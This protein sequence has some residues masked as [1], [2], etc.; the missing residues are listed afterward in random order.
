MFDKIIY[1]ALRHRL[2]VVCI[3]AFVCVYGMV[4]LRH[5]PVDVFP[6]LNRPTVTILTEMDG[7]APED[8]ETMISKPLET[9]I[10]GLPNLTRIFSSSVTGLS[11]VRAEF[12]W[13]TELPVARLAI[14]ERLQVAKSRLPKDVVPF[15]SPSSSIMAEIQMIGVT[16]KDG[17]VSPAQL[18]TVADWQVRPK[19]LAIAGVSQ[20]SVLGGQAQEIEI[21]LDPDK[22]ARKQISLTDLAEKLQKLSL[23]S[24]GGFLQA[25]GREWLIRNYGRIRNLEDIGMTA[26]G[27]HFGKPVLLSDV[28]TI[29]YAGAPRR[30]D[31]SVNGNVG[32]V[33]MIQKQTGVDTVLLT[34]KI[35]EALNELNPLLPA[36]VQVEKDL[37]KQSS[38]IEASIGNV[39]EALRDGSIMVAIV[40]TLFL[41]NFRATT[42]TLT[43]LP[44]SLLIS[45]IVF[46]W[47][48]L[49]VNTMTLGGLAIAIGELV[50]DAIVD[51]E[52]VLRRLRENALRATPRPMLRVIFEAS[53]EIRNSIVIATLIVVL[54][55]FP[56]FFLPGLEGR[57][58]VPIGI[59]YV[60]SLVASLFVSVTVTPVMCSYLFKKVG[61]HG[62]KEAWLA[63]ILKAADRSILERILD[64][65]KVV[66]SAALVMLVGALAII[67]LLGRDFLP[68]FNEGSAMAEI[69]LPTGVSLD[70]SAEVA[71]KAEQALREV[72][73]VVS[74]ATRTGRSDDDE[75]A[76]GVNRSEMEIALRPSARTRAEVFDDIRDKVQSVLPEDGYVGITQPI[77][78][79]IDHI[80]S[81][82]KSQVAIKLFGADQRVLRQQGAEIR[83]AIQDVPGIVDLRVEGQAHFPQY[84]IYAER[85]NLAK[86]GMM[87]GEFVGSLEAMLQ[88]VHL[89]PILEKDRTV[90]VVLRLDLKH[91]DTLDKIKNLPVYA[92]P[93][94]T[95][96]KLQDVADAF[97]TSGPNAI[98]RENQRRR[99]VVSFNS[100]GRDLDSLMQDVSANL[101]A[102]L[103]L[104]EG[105]SIEFDGQY[106]SQQRA[107]RLV[108]LLGAVSLLAVFVVLIV[109]FRSLSVALQI[110]INVPLALIGAVVAVYLADGILSVASLIAFITLCGIATRNGIM[111]ISHYIHLMVEEG[112]DFNKETIIR[113]SMD[114]LIPVLMTALSAMLALTP[115]LFAKDAAGKEILH[116]LAVVIV[117]GLFSSTLLDILLTPVI[118]YR[119]GRGSIERLRA[120]KLKSSQQTVQVEGV[121]YEEDLEYSR[122]SIRADGWR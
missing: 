102:K 15:V 10:S 94:G 25:D 100:S 11:I 62:E 93:S 97:E 37:F 4:A 48:G 52:N 56:L 87:P 32:V 51:V 45:V 28:A 60:V 83:N 95:I 121:G 117:G 98:E 12:E 99:L 106:K 43:A 65:P 21:A 2:L 107:M 114:R 71:R 96:V 82:V 17:G 113:G 34:Q 103:E 39:E 20:I 16:A 3:A 70:A 86:Y 13:S 67:P 84:K 63:A 53:R 9:A 19:L 31:A 23:T 26:I 27:L 30:G 81:G 115:L 8:I 110:M 1:L 118:F 92:T 57:L 105:Y 69:E 61:V 109:N 7:V 36:G 42:I 49:S 72:P 79:R 111:M 55:F 38:F 46:Q 47:F 54:V 68:G 66:L 22:L 64:R 75:E 77:S 91:R 74:T 41:L 119:F 112:A 122:S 80:V 18:R 78:H 33:L 5:L 24:S 104:P 90:P 88:G 85:E 76:L 35:D 59:A 44:L 40:L 6:D 116:P 120:L 108:S 73:E 29:R 50:D 89:T 58:F 14:N 101:A